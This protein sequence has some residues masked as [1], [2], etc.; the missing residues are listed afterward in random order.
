MYIDQARQNTIDLWEAAEN[1]DWR[2]IRFLLNKELHKEMTAE[3]NAQSTYDYT[4]LHLA[5]NQG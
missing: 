5:A 4:A 1:N 3:V 2:K